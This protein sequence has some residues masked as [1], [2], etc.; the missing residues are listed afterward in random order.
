MLH[1]TCQ[2]I[3]LQQYGDFYQLKPN[4]TLVV[5]LSEWQIGRKSWYCAAA[6]HFHLTR[7]VLMYHLCSIAMSDY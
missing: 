5:M 3:C 4:I 1:V 7:L 2:H 6:E